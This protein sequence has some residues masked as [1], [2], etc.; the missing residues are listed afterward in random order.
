VSHGDITSPTPLGEGRPDNFL[1]SWKEIAVYLDRDVRTVQRWEKKEGLP[2]HRQIHEKIGTVYGYKSEIDAWWRERSAKLSSKAENREL[3][4]GPRIVS[5]PARMQVQG[6]NP[7]T[8]NI[9]LAVLPFENLSVDPEQGYLSDGMT[10]ELTTRFGGLEPEKLSVIARSSVMQFKN[11]RLTAREIGHLLGVDYLLAGSVRSAAGRVRVSA[12]LIQVRDQSHLWARN[13]DR[14]MGDLLTIENDIAHAIANEVQLKLSAKQRVQLSGSAAQDPDAQECYLKGRYYSVKENQAGLT[15]AIS[16]YQQAIEK[17]PQYASPYAG[18]SA[19]YIRLGHWLALPPEQAFPKARAAALKALKLDGSL[20]EAHAALADVRLLYDWDWGKAETG[21]RKA[22]SLN[23]SSVQALRSYA[24]FLLAMRRFTESTD[25]THRAQQLDPD[26]V[27]LNA[28]AA[29][30]LYS[31]RQYGASIEAAR[32]TLKMDPGYSTGHLFLGLNYEQ[33]SRHDAAI[34]EL[35]EAVAAAGVR[36]Y[37]AHVARA[38]AV[39][40]KRDEAEKILD[41]LREESRH[42]YVSP[43][44]FALI[45][46]GLGDKDRAF[47]CL[48]EC[49]QKREHDLAYSNIWP[50]FDN[51]HSDPRWSRLVRRVGLAP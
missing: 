21:Y 49:Y 39:S 22:L 10:E 14:T 33:T 50:Q 26:S 44:L 41:E 23:P 13:Y 19:A 9:K 3:D 29:V 35:R 15:L 42:S 5:L 24:S 43:W 34:D 1:D 38:L 36:S 45:Y 40:G 47:D 30:Q 6:A 8:E 37:M 18:L 51:L 7:V 28:F 20:S 2:V 25:L 16:L 31:T 46:S 12:Q 11:T 17:A 4:G 32:K 27:Y 48:E